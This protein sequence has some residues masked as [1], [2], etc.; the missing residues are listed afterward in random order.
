MSEIPECRASWTQIVLEGVRVLPPP[1]RERVLA[2]L[3]REA[4]ATIEGSFGLRWLPLDLHMRLLGACH[5]EMERGAFRAFWRDRMLHS[6]EHPLLFA[7]PTRAALAA[8]G[9]SPLSL[10]RAIPT[11]F[12]YVM[13]GA[14]EQRARVD[15]TA[16]TA[17]FVHDG[18][19]R[20]HSEGHV[21]A[22]AWLGALD[23][24]A[25]YAVSRPVPVV[26]ARHDPARGHF[27]LVVGPT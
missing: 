15:E 8:F 23:G 21:W 17:T 20:A 27:E 24:I 18:F 1:A 14:G 25:Y 26:L 6:L 5:A 3:G 12:R 11:S 10:V 9:R 22:D 16:R 7:K 4:Q 19:P 13:R 2:R